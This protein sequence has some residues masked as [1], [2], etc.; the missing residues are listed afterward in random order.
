METEFQ[1]KANIDLCEVDNFELCG[2]ITDLVPR[3]HCSTVGGDCPMINLFIVI[4]EEGINSTH[5]LHA[6]QN[7]CCVQ[8]YH[9]K[10]VA[11]SCEFIFIV[12]YCMYGY[13]SIKYMTNVLHSNLS[14]YTF[15]LNNMVL[16]TLFVNLSAQFRHSEINVYMQIC[17]C[18]KMH[19]SVLNW[20]GTTPV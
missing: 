15:K 10:T 16:C 11:Y 4:S 13:R 17:L 3:N 2:L 18:G 9:S 5:L 6:Q 7:H 12:L 19:S 1:C 14:K 8:I 20:N